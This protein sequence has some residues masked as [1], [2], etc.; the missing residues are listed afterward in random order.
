ML[1]HAWSRIGA[2]L[3]LTLAAAVL[4]TLVSSGVGVYYFEQGGDS[5]HRIGANTVPALQGAHGAESSAQQ[6]HTLAAQAWQGQA[7]PEAVGATLARLEEQLAETGRDPA[8]AEPANRLHQAA[9]AQAE[10]VD[11]LHLTRTAGAAERTRGISLAADRYSEPGIYRD[12]QDLEAILKQLQATLSRWDRHYA[13]QRA[14]TD[15]ANL[16]THIRDTLYDHHPA[17][18]VRPPAESGYSP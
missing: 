11:R 17:Y 14:Y 6:L 10:A 18:E 16:L 3:Y 12:S 1:K 9:Y 4:L 5:A 13:G 7:P 15:L 8:L 2:R